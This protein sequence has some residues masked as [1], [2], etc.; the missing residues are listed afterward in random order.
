ML[1]KVPTSVEE[2][3]QCLKSRVPGL[4]ASCFNFLPAAS[5]NLD[6]IK[7]HP[8]KLH[9][10]RRVPRALPKR[11]TPRPHRHAKSQREGVA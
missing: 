3:A 8:P 9:E 7:V 5:F 1:A 11:R 2:F 4:A 6:L 10:A